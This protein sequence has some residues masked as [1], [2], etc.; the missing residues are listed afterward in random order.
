[1]SDFK[2]KTHQIICRLGL[3]PRPRWGAYSAPPDLSWILG[4]LL[5]RGEWTRGEGKG[6]EG[7]GGKGK[8]GEER[9]KGEGKEGGKD[10][11]G[12]RQGRPQAKA[13]PRPELYSWRR[14]CCCYCYC[15]C[16]CYFQP[17][18]FLHKPRSL[19]WVPKHACQND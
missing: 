19:I 17:P 13:C 4:G 10:G 15:C 2:V 6:R 3:R 8:G 9:G 18:N 5:L 16:C 7:K 1:M 14:R 11:E 12:K